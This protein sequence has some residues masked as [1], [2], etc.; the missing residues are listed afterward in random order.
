V[1]GRPSAL[2]D[3]RSPASHARQLRPA[4][5]PRRGSRAVGGFDEHSKL[6][7][8]RRGCCAGG[9]ALDSD[10]TECVSPHPGD[11]Q[12]SVPGLSRRGVLVGRNR[13]SVRRSRAAPMPRMGER[14]IPAVQAWPGAQPLTTSCRPRARRSSV[15]ECR[16][17]RPA[18]QTPPCPARSGHAGRGARHSENTR[19]A[20]RHCARQ[21]EAGTVIRRTLIDK[22]LT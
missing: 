8:P 12:R 20:W 22:H 19:Y 15:P 10:G 3:P 4:E 13:V 17:A 7:C 6:E 16:P 9:G 11:G 1:P 5:C 2:L 18:S 21:G 14:L